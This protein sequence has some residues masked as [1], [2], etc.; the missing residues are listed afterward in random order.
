MPTKLFLDYHDDC[1]L[2]T[3][4]DEESAPL[5]WEK[6]QYLHRHVNERRLPCPTF[7]LLRLSLILLF[8]EDDLTTVRQCKVCL[9]YDLLALNERILFEIKCKRM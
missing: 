7:S 5:V 9:I 4:L 1:R 2:K 3:S 8:R 6:R